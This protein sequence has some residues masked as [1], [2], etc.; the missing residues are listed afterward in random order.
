[1]GDHSLSPL[2]QMAASCSGALL[3]SFLVTPF[4]VVK[5]RLQAQAQLK[6]QARCPEC[7]YYL[8]S[9]GLM[10]HL[11]KGNTRMAAA[12]PG[13][14]QFSGTMDAMVKI[15]RLE[16]L[17]SLW[18]GLSPTLI[19]AVP[20]T[21]IYFT[22]YDQLRDHFLQVIPGSVVAPLIAGATARI[23][24]ATV[25]SPLE[26]IRTKVQSRSNYGYKELAGVVVKSVRTEGV[27]SLWR[28]L[29]PTL[30]R[31]VPFSAIYWSSYETV[32][33]IL[34]QRASLKEGQKKPFWISFT[35]G[36]VSGMIAATITTPFDVVKTNLQVT[37]GELGEG[38]TQE[39][40]PTW[41]VMR[42]IVAQQGVGG[43]FTGLTARI[44]KVAPACAVMIS[45]YELG[46]EFF[47]N[48]NQARAMVLDELEA[49]PADL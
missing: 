39:R 34:Q 3:T 30:L 49:S 1:M 48:K 37:M 7:F 11:C 27:L 44:A 42:S 28:G 21:V 19:M 23:F 46:K 47:R 26:L 29:V 40:P 10:D 18:R 43:L 16:G 14:I 22:M 33:G 15:A 20:A 4:D 13:G 38:A 31:D 2:Q 41:R 25:I 8:Y 32:G 9:N 6:A 17:G 36:A 45:S 35:A 5:V 12:A 24:S